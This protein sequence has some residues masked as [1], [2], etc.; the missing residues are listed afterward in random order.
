MPIVLTEKTSPDAKEY[1]IYLTYKSS[2]Y[3]VFYMK[4]KSCIWW[5]MYSIYSRQLSTL[6]LIY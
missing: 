3:Q 2:F 1:K 5:D 6:S 4:Y